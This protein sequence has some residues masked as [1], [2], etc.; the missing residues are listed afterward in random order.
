MEKILVLKMKAGWNENKREKTEND[1][2]IIH[3]F[4]YFI[5]YF[6]SKFRLGASPNV[7]NS[8]TLRSATL[9]PSFH[10]NNPA[11]T[12]VYHQPSH[13][14]P[15]QY[16]VTESYTVYVYTVREGTAQY[17]EVSQTIFL[18]Y[19][20][21]LLY[22]FLFWINIRMKRRTKKQNITKNKKENIIRRSILY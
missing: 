9:P 2:N 6:L 12:F 14:V 11:Y 1:N 10:F 22:I 7:Y 4:I 21:I 13:S 3:L 15:F 17:D 16:V 20:Y 18:I 5:L 8:H 19:L